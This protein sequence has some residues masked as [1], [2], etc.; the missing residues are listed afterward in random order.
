MQQTLNAT[1]MKSATATREKNSR[2]RCRILDRKLDAEGRHEAVQSNQIFSYRA[3]GAKILH[4]SQFFMIEPMGIQPILD[5]SETK[6]SGN[7][8]PKG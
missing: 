6:M 5:F 1:P 8:L 7:H 4:L 2:T 3:L